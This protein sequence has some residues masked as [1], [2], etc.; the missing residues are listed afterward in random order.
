MHSVDRHRFELYPAILFYRHHCPPPPKS[1]Y[2]NLQ[3]S[4]F[5]ATAISSPMFVTWWFHVF[6]LFHFL[7]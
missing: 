3:W 2:G 6:I 1:E 7:F 4:D 5:R